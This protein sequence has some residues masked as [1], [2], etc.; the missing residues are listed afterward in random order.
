M[1]SCC[2]WLLVSLECAQRQWWP[3][4]GFVHTVLVRS[5]R[6]AHGLASTDATELRVGTRRARIDREFTTADTARQAP[7]PAEGALERTG[8][9]DTTD[10]Y[11]AVA[12]AGEERL[13]LGEEFV[14]TDL[15]RFLGV[16]IEARAMMAVRL[17]VVCHWHGF[18]FLGLS[19]RAGAEIAL[20][21][22]HP[23]RR[24]RDVSVPCPTEHL[25][26]SAHKN[27]GFVSPNAVIMCVVLL[28][29]RWT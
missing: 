11:P 19:V 25:S 5:F 18:L 21:G 24:M 20:S 1:F 15:V 23:S 16:F 13:P 10:R 27:K 7:L 14:D 22:L 3:L 29:L 28:L 12:H 8:S 26:S 2:V 9:E 4:L 6:L 17:L